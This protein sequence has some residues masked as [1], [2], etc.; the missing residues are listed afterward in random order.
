MKELFAGEIFGSAMKTYKSR[1]WFFVGAMLFAELL[2]VLCG[3]LFA[4][5]AALALVAGFLVSVAV[6]WF[7]LRACRGENVRVLDFFDTAKDFRTGKRVFCATGWANL[8]IL[9]WGLIPVAGIVFAIIRYYEYAFVPYLLADRKDLAATEYKEESKK[10]TQGYKG[11]MF[12]IDFLFWVGVV[13]VVGI[14]LLLSLIPYVGIVF[15][16][17]AVLFVLSS[18]AFIP[19]LLRIIHAK[20]YLAVTAPVK[21]FVTADGGESGEKDK[22]NGKESDNV[23]DK[24]NVDEKE[25]GKDGKE[26]GERA[27]MPD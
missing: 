12:L 19:P 16:V 13:V 15:D 8:W 24:E 3:A 23:N 1:F 27:A 17:L 11:K 9:I 14:L 4:G 26:D 7:Y 18:L 25:S 21:P 2:A 5:I 10:L 6:D 20:I 22:F